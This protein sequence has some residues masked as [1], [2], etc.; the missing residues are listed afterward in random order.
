MSRRA[1][2]PLDAMVSPDLE[3][4]TIEIELKRWGEQ[5]IVKLIGRPITKPAHIGLDTK[6]IIE[7]RYLTASGAVFIEEMRAAFA[8]QHSRKEADK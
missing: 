7:T 6:V 4:S 5:P 1:I 8:G 3:L 2:R